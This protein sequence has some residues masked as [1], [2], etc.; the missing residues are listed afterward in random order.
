MTGCKRAPEQRRMHAA[1]SAEG[2]D[3]PQQVVTTRLRGVKA[4][5]FRKHGFPAEITALG[6]GLEGESYGIHAG[7]GRVS[8][9]DSTKRAALAR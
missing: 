4:M 3:R 9:P 8:A 1:G 7:D 2:A 5:H 6:S